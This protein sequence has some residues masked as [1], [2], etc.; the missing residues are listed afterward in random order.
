MSYP[1]TVAVPDVGAIR[2]VNILIVVV[3]SALL[4]PKNPKIELFSILRFKSKTAVN[5]PYFLVRFGF[6]WIF[7]LFALL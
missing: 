1:A 2:H 4:C 5:E 7:Q 3:F 6:Y